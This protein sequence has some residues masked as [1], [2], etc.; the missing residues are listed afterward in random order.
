MPIAISNDI[1]ISVETFYQNDKVNNYDGNYMFVY[2][3]TIEN[4]GDS[5]VKL[6][7]RHWDIVDSISGFSEVDGDGVVGLQP[8]LEPNEKHTYVSG[9]AIQG[10]FG[11]MS[12]YYVMQRQIDGKEFEVQ[13]PSFQFI[14]PFVNN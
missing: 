7:R 14:V 1:K 9:C 8:V 5:T 10:H 12:G 11:K 4:L 6:I 13:I 3:I 2:R